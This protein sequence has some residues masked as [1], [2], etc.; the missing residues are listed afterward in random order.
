MT[1]VN[2]GGGSDFVILSTHAVSVCPEFLLA[3]LQCGRPGFDPWVGKIP[4]R[5]KWQSTLGLLPGK[6]HGEK[7]LVGTGHGVTKSRTQLSD[8]TFFLSFFSFLTSCSF[9]LQ[10]GC[11]CLTPLSAWTRSVYAC[12]ERP[13]LSCTSLQFYYDTIF[14]LVSSYHS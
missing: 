13:A 10:F 7:S 5:R 9:P 1:C 12:L 3:C 11:C 8:F 4:W 2:L 6:S 14:T